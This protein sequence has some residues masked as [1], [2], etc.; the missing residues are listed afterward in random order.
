MSGRLVIGIDVG[1]T[2]TDLFFL[3]EASGETWIGKVPS[4][5]GREAAGCLNGIRQ[6]TDDLSRVATIV[7]GTTV[8]TNALLER[9]GGKVGVI[10]TEGF[11]DV[12]EMRRRDRPQTWGLWGQ[13][14]P[15]V[16]RERRLEVAE[17]MLADGTIRRGVDA[18]EVKARARQLLALGAQAVAV[19]FINSYANAANE[20]VAAEALKSVWPNAYVNVS[21]EI[22]PEI[23]EFERA[24][25]TALNAYLQP[26]VADYLDRL[27]GD[28]AADAFAGQLLIV[29]SNGGVMTI[30]TAKARPVRTALSGPAA[31]V[32]AAAHIAKT[33]GFPNVV[34]GDIGG[35]SFDVSLISGGE[36]AH[37]AQTA[38]DFGL[39]VRT[40]MIEITTIGAGGGS[41]AF[42]DRGGLLQ[43]GPESAGAVPGP[44]C[45]GQGNDRPTLTDAN[46]VLGRINPERPIGGGLARLDVAAAR[47]AIKKHI[48]DPLGLD[49]VAAAEA[50]VRVANSRMAGAIR[51]VSIERGHNPHDFAIMPFGGGGALHAGALMKEVG[52]KAA[53]VPPY[54][55]VISALGCVIADMR[56]DFVQTLNRTLT[57]ID[58]SAFNASV[59]GLAAEGM[60]L[61]DRSGVAFT[62]RETLV[63][64]DM[65]YLGQTH[66]VSVPIGADADYVATIDAMKLAFEVRYREVYGRLLDGIPIR[67]MNLHVAV[68]GRRP[69]L[70]LAKLAP[71][72]GTVEAARQDSRSVFV[73]GAWHEAAIYARRELP[74]GAEV[75][76]PAILEQQDATVFIEPDLKGRVDEFGNIIIERYQT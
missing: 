59:A 45:Y 34:T 65:L 54:P 49:P 57:E 27:E 56:Y 58:L 64:C 24:S 29:Q 50:V 39:V 15:V 17:R 33:A 43:V 35:T 62:G 13:F 55:G 11:R 5:R 7:H 61:L 19:T 67:A 2:F 22:L 60:Q 51:L 32:I 68:I 73:D 70:D 75:K 14:E 69:K 47:A 25:T 37:A 21:S 28:L 42:V 16:P 3:D 8:G 46:V 12:L 76:G 1:G 38:I 6:G 40:P 71:K 63:S 10:A 41:I 44:V 66:T 36:T 74:V 31:G 26:V 4:T 18:E 53:L 23:R 72:A 48:G 52:L 20:R 30:E 9:K